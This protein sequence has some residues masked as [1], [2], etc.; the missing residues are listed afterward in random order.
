MKDDLEDFKN[1]PL[2]KNEAAVER[3]AVKN[4]YNSVMSTYNRYAPK[5]KY[6]GKTASR[7]ARN[8]Y[9]NQEKQAYRKTL[10]TMVRKGLN[11]ETRA[12]EY[13]DRYRYN[14]DE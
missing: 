13:I 9:E 11:K 10:A 1:F 12:A 7:E 6:P 5:G 3:P 8:R 14:W 2:S 4:Y